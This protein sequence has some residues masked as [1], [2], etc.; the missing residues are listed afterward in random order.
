MKA[1]H[2]GAGNIGRGFVGLLLHEAGY[3]VVFA[4]VADALITQLAGADS[5]SVHEVGENPAVRTVDNFRAVNSGTQEAQLI[6]EIA[7]A[8]IVTTAVGPH[9]LKF[10][11]PAIAKGIAARATGLPPLQ[12]MACENAINATDLLRESIVQCWDEAAGSLQDSAVFA[13]TAVDRIVPNQEPGQGLDVTVETFYEWV[14]DRTPFGGAAPVIPG[15]TFVDELGPYI[16]RKL[17]TVNTGHASAAY[18]GFEAGLE[19]ISDAMADEDVAADVRAVLEETKQLLVS[20][21]G[22]SY[23]EQEA[24][25]Q[26]ILGRFTNPHLPDTVH[27]VGRAPLRKLSRHERFIGPAA[28]LAERGIVPEAL[29]G[30]IAAA[31]R[32][33]DPA[34]AEAVELG[35]I[36]AASEPAAATERITGL[37]QDHPLFSAVCGLVEERKAEDV[38]APA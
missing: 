13:N 18:F 20:K 4:D 3:E 28:E 34:D 32:F 14:I 33:N 5:Y 23:D 29:L 38:A 37:A 8:D 7:T 12:V 30:A 27:R 9:I 21:H 35:Q 36:L 22:F 17:F 2:F 31:L 24:Y 6:E 16:E 19:K 25:V 15:A 11:A 10:V 26:K 1:V